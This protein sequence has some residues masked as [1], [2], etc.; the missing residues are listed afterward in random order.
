MPRRDSIIPVAPRRPSPPQAP[1][2]TID[3][4]INSIAVD[5]A[6]APPRALPIKPPPNEASSA[7]RRH[8]PLELT[9]F[10]KCGGCGAI[11][12]H[13]SRDCPEKCKL[14]GLN[15]CPGNRGM[16]CAIECVVQPS[17]SDIKN[18]LGYP[19]YPTLVTKLDQLWSKEHNKEI[20]VS[21][22]EFCQV[23]EDDEEDEEINHI[24]GLCNSGT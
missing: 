22:A 13:L 2:W 4:L 14:C 16:L 8:P 24:S 9:Q 19:M 18:A 20:E 1:P 3:K 17:K 6:R 23:V 15:F 12:K 21:S 5:L 10:T 7:D 11:G